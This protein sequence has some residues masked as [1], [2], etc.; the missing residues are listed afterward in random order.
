MRNR[1]KGRELG[2]KLTTLTGQTE[3][4][5][6]IDVPFVV[7]STLF[8]DSLEGILVALPDGSTDF[9]ISI[10]SPTR[11]LDVHFGIEKERERER[12]QNVPVHASHVRKG[13]FLSL[14]PMVKTGLMNI[15]AARGSAPYNL[16]LLKLKLCEADWAFTGDFFA[17]AAG[18]LIIGGG[19]G[20]LH[21]RSIGENL[22]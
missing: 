7:H 8:L 10:C 6:D 13:L 9:F 16:L 3:V 14:G 19:I 2:Y 15:V 1:R 12:E 17:F 22:S 18:A 5:T 4:G 20:V 21:D 11:Y